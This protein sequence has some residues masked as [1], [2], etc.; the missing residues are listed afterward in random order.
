MRGE[1]IQLNHLVFS[2]MVRPE[3]SICFPRMAQQLPYSKVLILLWYT[4]SEVCNRVIGKHP[5]FLALSQSVP[6]NR[7]YI[8]EEGCRVMPSNTLFEGD[9]VVPLRPSMS[10]TGRDKMRIWEWNHPCCGR[11]ASSK[12]SNVW[13]T[14]QLSYI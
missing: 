12:I 4:S 13:S 2:V 14:F 11:W 5:S 8:K 1:Q 3:N 9:E 6:T 10:S 7:R